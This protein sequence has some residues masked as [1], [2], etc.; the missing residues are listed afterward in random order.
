[1]IYFRPITPESI[2]SEEPDKLTRDQHTCI[3]NLGMTAAFFLPIAL[4]SI[5]TGGYSCGTFKFHPI[6]TYMKFWGFFYF[7][8]NCQFFECIIVE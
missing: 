4:V 1:M 2:D 3:N 7:G 5:L 6:Y 8:Y